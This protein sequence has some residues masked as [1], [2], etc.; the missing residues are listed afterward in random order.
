MFA[1][2]DVYV[3]RSLQLQATI[4]D[5]QQ[6]DLDAD[7][8]RNEQRQRLRVSIDSLRGMRDVVIMDTPP[9]LGFLMTTSL[10][11]ADLYVVPIFPSGYELKGLE[12]LARTTEKIRKRFN[13]GLQLLGVVVGNFDPSAKLDKDI[14]EL[15]RNRFGEEFVFDRVITRSVRHREATIYGQTIFEIANG[16]PAAEQY[17]ELGRSIIERLIAQSNEEEEMRR[18]VNV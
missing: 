8:I 17:R 14:L 18:A 1:G 12:N 5:G 13:P 6:S 11:A 9:S 4:A 7:D 15:L 2:L 3:C 10:I 16:S